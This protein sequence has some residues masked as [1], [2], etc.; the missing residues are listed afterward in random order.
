[1][2]SI[3]N[4]N[5]S[6]VNL[7]SRLNENIIGYIFSFL[8]TLYELEKAKYICRYFKTMITKTLTYD[9]LAYE[10]GGYGDQ[11]F[12]VYLPSGLKKPLALVLVGKCHLASA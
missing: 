12:V 8:E 3:S 1:M 5:L 9:I 7:F 4:I 2:D 6:K 11:N 10:K